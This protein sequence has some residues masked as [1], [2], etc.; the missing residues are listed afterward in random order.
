MF[1]KIGI[2]RAFKKYS[3]DSFHSP[4]IIIQHRTSD[5][6][7]IFQYRISDILYILCIFFHGYLSQTIFA[8]FISQA[9]TVEYTDFA[10]NERNTSRVTQ[11]SMKHYIN[12]VFADVNGIER[13]TRYDRTL[14]QSFLSSYYL[15]TIFVVCMVLWRSVL[16]ICRLLLL[17]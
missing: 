17:R 2:L 16:T 12:I 4:N 13:K 14:W 1:M 15:T 5:V 8:Y 10:I 3:R 9:M 6:L 11:F 7:D